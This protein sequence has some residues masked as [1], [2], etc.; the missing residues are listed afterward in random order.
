MTCENGQKWSI[1]FVAGDDLNLF[2]VRPIEFSLKH[3][4]KRYDFARVT[5]PTEVGESLRPHIDNITT[6]P[7]FGDY[8]VA[9]FVYEDEVVR[10]MLYKPDWITFGRDYTH[11]QFRDLQHS[12]KDGTIDI[13]ESDIGAGEIYEQVIDMAENNIIE[14]V[15]YNLPDEIFTDSFNITTENPNI[16]GFIEEGLTSGGEQFNEN[17]KLNIDFDDKGPEQIINQIN[18]Y[19]NLQTWA[20]NN[21]NLAVGMPEY[22]ENGHVAAPNDPRVWRYKEPQITL[23]REPIKYCYVEGAWYDNPGWDLSDGIEEVKAQLSELVENRGSFSFS[24]DRQG[25]ADVQAVGIAR[26]T[27]IS[28]GKTI[29]MQN[30]GL[31]RQGLT[32]AAKNKLIEAIKDSNKGTVEIDVNNSGTDVSHPVEVN[33]GDALRIVP[34]DK[35]FD[36]PKATSGSIGDAPPR[37]EI[38]GGFVTNNTYFVKEIEHSLSKSGYYSIHFDLSTYPDMNIETTLAFYDPSSEE[39]LQNPRDGTWYLPEND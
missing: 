18:D 24:P 2:E 27:D 35:Y 36:N 23:G 6:P 11:A 29:T 22:G 34:H 28:E 8:Q 26:R 39:W 21:R 33:P 5:F 16:D 17:I 32:D 31:T 3:N 25:G 30:V 15:V 4:R 38:C 19:L 20:T 14:G 10:Q 9:E 13:R 37:D 7:Q 12:L 1:R